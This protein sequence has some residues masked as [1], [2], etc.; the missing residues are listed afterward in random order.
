M[1]P[2]SPP[3]CSRTDTEP[4]PCSRSPDHEH[5]TGS[6]AARRRGS[7]APR[8]SLRSSS[9]TRSLPG[10]QLLGDGRG[11]VVEAIGDGQHDRLHRRQPQRQLAAVVLDQDPDEALE[12]AQQR[13]VDHHRAVLLVVGARVVRGR[14]ARASSSRA[15]PCRAARSARAS[16][17]CAGRSWVRRTRR[18][19]GSARTPAPPPRARPASAPSARSHISSLPI[20]FSGRVDSSRRGSKP[21][22]SYRSKPKRRHWT[23]S[24]CTCSSVQKMWASSWVMCRTRISPWS[25]PLGSWRCTRPASE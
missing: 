12:G 23:T 7:C 25:V 16:R 6:C 5:V 8:D 20:R 9:S 4:S 15:G 22:S 1:L 17:S 19:R 3:W 11:V 14:S 18:R 2:S 10:A 13:A 24:S 21:N